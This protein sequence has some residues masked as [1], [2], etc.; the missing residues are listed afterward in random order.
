[1]PLEAERLPRAAPTA[2]EINDG[3]NYILSHFPSPAAFESRLKKVGFS[4]VKD[5]N[6]ER[7]ISQRLAIEKYKDFRFGA[8]IVITPDDETKYYREFYVP[9]F[10]RRFPG[11]LMPTLDEKR[12]EIRALLTEQREGKAIES[13]LEEAKRR[14]TIEMLLEV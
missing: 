2:E 11:L 5:D 7:I 3:I 6:F 14:T 4:S 10:R 12:T 8:F 9:E 13:F 1:M